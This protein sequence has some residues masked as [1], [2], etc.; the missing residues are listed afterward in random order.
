MGF[1]IAGAIAAIIGSAVSAYGA[2]SQSQAQAAAARYNAK[3]DENQ[4]I[5]AQ[6]QAQVEMERRRE[7][8]K[9]QKGTQLALMGGSGIELGEG[10]PLLLEADSA[11]QAALDLARV[12]YEGQIK[13]TSYQSEANIQ[14]FSAR[15]A[16]RQG[17]VSAGASL[18]SGAG[19]A[20]SGYARSQV[21]TT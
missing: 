7:L 14:R 18:L 10:S 15:T 12:R 11:E 9:R 19:S 1:A 13:S 5:N 8:Y 16:T 4:A 3:L 20:A 17:Y 6:N 2:Y 21:G